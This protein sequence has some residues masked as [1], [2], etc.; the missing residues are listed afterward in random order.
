MSGEKLER[1]YTFQ[2]Q[3]QDELVQY[4][5]CHVLLLNWLPLGTMA[6]SQKNRSDLFDALYII[7]KHA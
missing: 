3:A 4:T 5:Q 6:L 1:D 2:D 7:R